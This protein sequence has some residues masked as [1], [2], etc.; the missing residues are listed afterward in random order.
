MTIPGLFIE[1]LIV[2]ALAL[3]WIYPLLP[4]PWVS[5]LQPAHL[6]LLA[7][8]LYVVG[9]VIDFFAWILTS[10]IKSGLRAWAEDGHKFAPRELGKIL[11]GAGGRFRRG[12]IMSRQIYLAI[13]AP[14]AAK[15]AAMR[16][17][18]DR[19]ARGAIINSIL[20]TIF[21]LPSR[22][23]IGALMI[24]VFFIMWIN[25]EVAS[26]DYE[27]RAE[28]LVKKKLAPEQD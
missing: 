28:E 6:P 24:L 1:Y 27:R 23:Y 18:R 4:E 13:H 21:A 15:E 9:M 17:S 25:F 14:E 20:F 11:Q 2:G 5:K 3:I 22:K 26:Y 8:G 10:Y 16:S 7:L 19:I 12:S